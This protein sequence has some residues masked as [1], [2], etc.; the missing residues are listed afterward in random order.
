MAIGEIGVEWNTEKDDWY[1][2][3]RIKRT[4]MMSKVV[5]VL[6]AVDFP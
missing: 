4:G 5:E 2:S 3:G 1:G 6:D